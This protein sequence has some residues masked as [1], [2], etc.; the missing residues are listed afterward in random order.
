MTLP[1]RRSFFARC[2]VG[3]RA[4]WTRLIVLADQVDVLNVTTVITARLR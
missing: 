3:E 4:D 2:V 1:K